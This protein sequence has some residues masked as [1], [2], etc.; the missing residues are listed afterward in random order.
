MGQLL[1]ECRVWMAAVALLFG[2]A[3]NADWQLSSTN[4]RQVSTTVPPVFQSI[5]PQCNLVLNAGRTADST[6]TL[7]MPRG[8]LEMFIDA[9]TVEYREKGEPLVDYLEAP[10][11]Q[12]H[13]MKPSGAA[14]AKTEIFY[15]YSGKSVT[16]E[17]QDLKARV[18]E[19]AWELVD[20]NNG[21]LGG[22][23]R[24]DP[25]AVIQT[26]PTDPEGTLVTNAPDG[27]AAANSAFW[28]DYPPEVY[29]ALMSNEEVTLRVY[30]PGFVSTGMQNEQPH[31]V[32]W[33]IDV[34]Q[35]ALKHLC[36]CMKNLAPIGTKA[37]S[38][39]CP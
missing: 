13:G 4:D 39:T 20:K 37:A 35:N 24:G 16:E 10:V 25:G 2:A 38:L 9:E 17:R 33:N 18:Y 26:P 3:A 1:R 19:I 15:R 8:T 6:G 34:G 27:D 32:S 21:W 31:Y 5:G 23:Q 22:G 14:E 7:R 30:F 11:I 36:T 28:V 12:F 29:N